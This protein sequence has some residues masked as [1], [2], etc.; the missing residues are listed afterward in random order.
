MFVL[1][2]LKETNP[3]YEPIAVTLAMSTC[4][5]MLIY[6]FIFRFYN[7]VTNFDY[8]LLLS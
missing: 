4:L 8:K 1:Y 3:S 5:L 7:R 2:A 6:G